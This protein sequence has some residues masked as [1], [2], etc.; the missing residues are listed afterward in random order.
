MTRKDRISPK[1]T[2][3]F[4]RRLAPRVRPYRATLYAASVLLLVSTAV[5]LAFPL[6]VRYLLDAAFLQDLDR[7]AMGLLGLF[8][9]QAFLNFGQSYLTASVSER[10]VADLRKDV[11]DRSLEAIPIGDRHGAGVCDDRRAGRSMG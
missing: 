3:G 11:F 8:F 4:L 5:G 1:Q 10:V 9:V 2:F 7:I 6:V